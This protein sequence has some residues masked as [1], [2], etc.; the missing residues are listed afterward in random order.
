MDPVA[1]G[2]CLFIK[3]LP[4]VSGLIPHVPPTAADN[5]SI[6]TLSVLWNVLTMTGQLTYNPAIIVATHSSTTVTTLWL[7]QSIL[8]WGD[9]FVSSQQDMVVMVTMQIHMFWTWIMYQTPAG[10]SLENSID[11]FDLHFCF[12]Y[13]K[14]VNSIFSLS[15]SIIII[16]S[17]LVASTR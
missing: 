1:P 6:S 17:W 7:M 14:V 8:G 13:R 12:C 15:L 4:F 10:K 2:H 16:T 5:Q 11:S 9:A 3:W